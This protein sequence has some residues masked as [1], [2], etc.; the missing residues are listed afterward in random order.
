MKPYLC[1]DC[2]ETDPDEFYPTKTSR[3][4]TCTSIKNKSNRISKPVLMYSIVL[5][6]SRGEI[7]KTYNNV[8]EV[9]KKYGVDGY[10][11]KS[12]IH[13]KRL[14]EN[15]EYFEYGEK[16]L[17]RVTRNVIKACDVDKNKRQQ[18]KFRK[19]G[20]SR[21]LKIKKTIIE[22]Y[23]DRYDFMEVVSYDGRWD[24]KLFDKYR[25]REKVVGGHSIIKRQLSKNGI[26]M[27]TYH[28]AKARVNRLGINSQNQYIKWKARTNQDDLPRNPETFY[29]EWISFYE[30]FNTKKYDSMSI[31]EKRIYN[32]LMK[33]NIEFECEKTF[34]GC[35][36]IMPL[37]FD[38]YLPSYNLLIEFDGEQHFKIG[39]F[40]DTLEE[41]ERKF[42]N[43]KKNDEIKTKYCQDNDIT[44]LRLHYSL[45]T[46][47][48]LEW[49]L[50]N[51]LTRI[52]AEQAIL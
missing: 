52:A 10:C 7:I 11:V 12:W 15:L 31:G 9:S 36:N 4:K 6:N 47:N 23:N 32:Y 40:A 19:A 37:R 30:F 49:E 14:S 22:D 28:E 27:A 16:T 51:E 24:V 25:N 8:N 48:V 41:N 18:F 35:K 50:D 45:L 43:C 1:K 13:G 34:D 20:S 3:C 42:K 2:G 33:K 21:E 39:N 46:D 5:K 38:F 44:L 26:K 17:Q 29:V